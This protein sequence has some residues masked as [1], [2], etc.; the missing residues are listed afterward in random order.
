MRRT[1]RTQ[2]D[3]APL[4]SDLGAPH[5]LGFR[6]HNFTLQKL[7]P[8]L[9]Q[10]CYGLLYI[11]LFLLKQAL[12]GW[13]ILNTLDGLNAALRPHPRH[14][15]IGKG[16]V[17]LQPGHLI[18]QQTA[19]ATRDPDPVMCPNLVAAIVVIAGKSVDCI[20][21]EKSQRNPVLLDLGLSP[22]ES[23][24]R[25]P[26]HGGLIFHRD[27]QD[28]GVHQLP[29][30]PPGPSFDMVLAGQLEPQSWLQVWVVF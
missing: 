1:P 25:I 19:E 17:H 26:A 3:R 8:L 21:W 15:H 2:F 11:I 24:V 4:F 12:H 14:L 5:F 13:S 7:L 23:T 18:L 22:T 30:S 16:I 6:L 10:G 20:G 29:E 27:L 28:R 9:N